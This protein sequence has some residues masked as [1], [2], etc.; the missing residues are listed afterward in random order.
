M[1]ADRTRTIRIVCD[2]MEGPVTV[3]GVIC[4][5]GTL[6]AKGVVFADGTILGDGI[7]LGDGL[8]LGDGVV[9]SDGTI[10]GDRIR[11][12]GIL[13]NGDDSPSMTVTRE[14]G[15]VID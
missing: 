3:N 11:S 9:V 12:L 14:D 4:A 8:I 2:G 6:L 7:I 13:V 10:L 1:L 15:T 5:D